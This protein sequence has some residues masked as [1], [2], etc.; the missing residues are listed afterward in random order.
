MSAVVFADIAEQFGRTVI[1]ILAVG[2]AA[3]AGYILTFII[4]WTVYRLAIHRPPPKQGIKILS[5][6][7]G[8]GAGVVV[9]MLLFNGAGGGGGDGWWPFG[10]AG[11]IPQGATGKNVTPTQPT[12]PKT[13]PAITD[14]SLAAAPL[15]VKV[16]GGKIPSKKFYV[17]DSET[18]ARD[19]GGVEK[20]ITARTENKP[21]VRELIVVLK[22]ADSAGYDSPAVKDLDAAGKRFGLSVGYDPPEKTK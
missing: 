14:T 2:G 21:P 7:C 13:T 5:S 10:G 18:D 19:L 8:I 12:P 20:V 22:D 4:T 1:N 6:L 9:A 15:R 17:V 3:A 16:L 11:G